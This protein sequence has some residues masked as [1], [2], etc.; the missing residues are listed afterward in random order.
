MSIMLY[1]RR[2]KGKLKL[3][4]KGVDFVWR[5]GVHQFPGSFEIGVWVGQQ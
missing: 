5:L 4:S 1:S 3:N 2:Q